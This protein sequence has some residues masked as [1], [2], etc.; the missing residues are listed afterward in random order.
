MSAGSEDERDYSYQVISFP[1]Y[2]DNN[3]NPYIDVVLS[4]WIRY[5]ND[6]K[7]FVSK[8]P[9]PPYNPTNL[10]ELNKLLR[11]YSDAPDYWSEYVI[12]FKG[13]ASMYLSLECILKIKFHYS[14][15]YKIWK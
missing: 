10:R 5:K 14:W 15:I 11:N 6:L 4:S 3:D 8:F 1:N 7:E 12:D 13:A 2:L 9:P